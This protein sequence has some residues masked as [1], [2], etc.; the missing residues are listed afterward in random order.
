MA[1]AAQLLAFADLPAVFA[2]YTDGEGAGC[3]GHAR[4][5]SG[6]RGIAMAY[7][8]VDAAFVAE[9]M[10]DMP[11]VD[12]RP[13]AYYSAGHV[14]GAINI[15]FDVVKNR[16]VGPQ[17]PDKSIEMARALGLRFKEAHIFQ[18]TPAIVMCQTGYHSK[19][20][21]EMLGSQGFTNLFLY[22]GSYQDWTSSPSRP[23]VKEKIY[24]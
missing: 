15:P 6:K 5:T 7:Q 17:G 10:N 22:E 24:A 14:P 13:S 18:W 21:C 23:I 12:V 1:T 16:T 4:K 9:H 11:I 20:A 19:L 2:S 8:V 3:A